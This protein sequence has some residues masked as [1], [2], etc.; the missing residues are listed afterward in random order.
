VAAL[1]ERDA[2]DPELEPSRAADMVYAF[3]A[4]DVHRILTVERGWTPEEYETWVIRC[5]QSLLRH[6]QH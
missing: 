1:V 4:P 2:L 6:D 5:L 3:M